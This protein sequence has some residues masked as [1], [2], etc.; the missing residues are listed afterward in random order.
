MM[1][2]QTASA[3]E[4]ACCTARRRLMNR[5]PWMGSA[6]IVYRKG[7]ESVDFPTEFVTCH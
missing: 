4:P 3:E 7:I 1:G 6:F 5:P 2:M